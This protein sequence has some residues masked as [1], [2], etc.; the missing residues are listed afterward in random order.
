VME[1]PGSRKLTLDDYWS[2]P[3]DGQRY[4][5]LEG[6]LEVTPS[7]EVRHQRVSAR[8]HLLF[9]THLARNPV[10]EVMYAPMDVILSNETVCQPDLLFIARDR[11]PLIVKDRIRGAPDLVLEI[12]SPST[13]LRDLNTKRDLYA[14][15]GIREYIV[16]DVAQRRLVRFAL[17]AGSYGE[18]DIRAAGERFESVAIPGFAFAV[19]ELFVQP[20]G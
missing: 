1:N 11:I 4:E 7:P 15:H 10:G 17:D 20:L 3:D 8:L 19:D 6:K 12:L 18:P 14:R 16:V 2:L 13:A 9:A 5:I